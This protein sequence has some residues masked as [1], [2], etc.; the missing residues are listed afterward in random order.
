MSDRLVKR[1]LVVD[2]FETTVADLSDVFLAYNDD[3]EGAFT[4]EVDATQSVHD[5]IERVRAAR[6][7]QYDVLVLDLSFEP[8]P[9]LHD[10]KGMEFAEALAVS[11]RLGQ[12]IPVQIMFTG[13][14]NVALAVEA[15]RAGMWDVIEKSQGDWERHPYEQVLDSAV[16]R[17]RELAFQE[18]LN[19]VVVP[20]LQQNVVALQAKHGGQVVAIWHDPKADPRVEVIASGQDAF[21]LELRLQEWRR[22]HQ[23]WMHPFV[24]Q[25]PEAKAPFTKAGS[26]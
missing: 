10:R 25:I 12:A 9:A 22:E 26:L 18:R 1:V 3:P 7:R 2:D 20:W 5:A 11:R 24:V 13:Y 16:A 15:M 21:E 19:D 6:D 8:D 17:L 14:A 4:F 23:S